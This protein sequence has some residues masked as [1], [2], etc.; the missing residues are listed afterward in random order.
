MGQGFATT[1]RHTTGLFWQT[2]LAYSVAFLPKGAS[3]PASRL[4]LLLAGDIERN[5]GPVDPCSVCKDNVT[6]KGYSFRCDVCILW[7]H[8]R[9][10]R[11]RIAEYRQLKDNDLPWICPTC[12]KAKSQ[13]QPAQPPTQ[14]PPSTASTASI[15]LL[16]WNC[17]GLRGKIDELI[18]YMD[19]ND[20]KVAAL[21]ETKLGRL[22]KLRNPDNYVI[23]RKDRTNFGD[24]LAFLIHNSIK[25]APY[26]LPNIGS[27]DVECD[28]IRLSLPSGQSMILANFYY[29]P[30]SSA[31]SKLKLDLQNVFNIPN[32]VC[33]GDFN[34][35]NPLWYSPLN[36]PRG[37]KLAKE[38]SKSSICCLNENFPTRLPPAGRPTSP[39]ISLASPNFA[40]AMTWRT[41]T[42]LP[43][44]H[45]PICLRLTLTHT[46]TTTHRRTTYINFKK[47]KWHLFTRY[48][49]NALAGIRPPNNIHKAEQLFRRILTRA[50]KRTIPAGH[51]PNATGNV[52]PEA[53]RLINQR[54]QIRRNDPTNPQISDLNNQ[55]N[56]LINT[57]K[58]EKW[59]EFVDSFDYRR[60]VS[61]LWRTVKKLND[62]PTAPINQSIEFG[63]KFVSSNLDIANCF[64]RQFCSI[65]PKNKLPSK[66][67]RRL[68]RQ[69]KHRRRLQWPLPPSLRFTPDQV[70]AAIKQSN[71]SRAIG[72]DGL[73]MLHLKHLGPN[74]TQ[75]LTELFT[76]S[77]RHCTIP[78]IW[79]KSII[80]PIPKPNKPASSSASYRP[81]SITSPVIKVLERLVLPIL[82]KEL[83]P[84]IH[85]HGFRPLH[86][87]TSALLHISSTIAAG[88]SEPKPASRTVLA[89]VD[90]SKAFDSVDH[91]RLVNKLINTGLPN[92][93]VRWL[94]AYLRG[95]QASTSFNGYRSRPRCVKAGVPQGSVISPILFNYFVSDCPLPDD[96]VRAISYADDFSFFAAHSNYKAAVTELNKYLPKLYNW[97]TNNG[98][99]I[100]EPK[101]TATLFT[102]HTHEYKDH[103]K[104]RLQNETLP[105]EQYPSIL[106]VKFDPQFKFHLHVDNICARASR[107]L[108]V[109]KALTGTTWGQ[110]KETLSLLYKATIRPLFNYACPVWFPAISDTSVKKMQ[111]VQNYACRII[112]GC[113]K[114]TD[115]GHLHNETGLLP[116]AAHSDLLC[117]QYFCSS[118]LDTHPCRNLHHY[119]RPRP[120]RHS[121]FTR[122]KA[123][124]D[125]HF[126][127]PPQCSKDVKHMMRTLHTNIVAEY[128]ESTT[129]KVLNRMAPAV[130]QTEQSLDRRARCILAQLRSGYSSIL[131]NT[132][133]TWDPNVVDRCPSCKQTPH[134]VAHIFNCPNNPT[135]LPIDALWTDPIAVA[136]LI[137]K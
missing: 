58:K 33:L 129:N 11:L 2:E 109:L 131:M 79:K 66:E 123:I 87:T 80:A 34:A 91:D 78:S 126:S 52:P 54:D 106:G 6:T 71:P 65:R 97:A 9:C 28:G 42:T 22:A 43:S 116:I 8:Q 55:I 5:P 100:S 36:D 16:Q 51:I 92:N 30:A 134:D 95:R 101:S 24:G 125:R 122:Y 31:P 72:P 67:I 64:N 44:D 102:P 136:Q 47:A 61:T 56:N 120:Q 99:A 48:V 19:N 114:K 53:I 103:P 111:T 45:L 49:E 7:C 23:V 15:N 130:D 70:T 74:A 38:I 60:N 57:R 13:A 37:E 104:L 84:A 107:R 25:F 82:K 124:F 63:G 35:H 118:L 10:C 20:I 29:P 68:N 83:N 133:N 39:D 75:Y 105:R 110:Q 98:L 119:N 26:S 132:R 93:L 94:A 81:I 137:S 69:L 46:T 14:S 90:I 113:V 85:Q 127:D 3:D 115:K 128:R 32:I 86:S 135:D 59:A 121:L 17:N 12:T 88:F 40:T 62:Q 41:D 117:A 4:L 21:Q 108:N 50:A 96:P 27:P 89:T 1:E 73:C 77:I 76:R 112:T 18:L